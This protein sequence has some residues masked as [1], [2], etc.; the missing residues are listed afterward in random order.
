MTNEDKSPVRGFVMVV[1]LEPIR[2]SHTLS[3]DEITELVKSKPYITGADTSDAV[4][5]IQV[6]VFPGDPP[7]S[8]TFAARIPYLGNM[9]T[10]SIVEMV[11][12]R[13]GWKT[14]MESVSD[15]MSNMLPPL[16]GVH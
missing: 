3:L 1:I 2:A 11:E 13:F 6:A 10:A 12:R 5:A 7:D 8:D 14:Q 4:S 9:G 16:K 15:E